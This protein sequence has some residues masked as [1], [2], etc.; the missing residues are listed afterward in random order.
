MCMITTQGETSI[1][2]RDITCWK[3]VEILS[4][5][6][7]ERIYATPYMFRH[8][9]QDVLDGKRPFWTGQPERTYELCEGMCNHILKGFIHTY[10]VPVTGDEIDAAVS[11]LT[12][13]IASVNSHE[14]YLT[15][16][17]MRGLPNCDMLPWVIGVALYRCV[18][19]KGTEYLEGVSDG[20]VDSR[21]YASREI[22]FKEKVVEWNSRYCPDMKERIISVINDMTE[23]GIPM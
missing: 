9:P 21:C 3:V 19:P 6:D 11:E 22:V 2:D 17:K 7:G 5:M 16:E 10:A 20:S 8:V 4:D 14:T 13:A 12:Y 18:I 15:A 23:R 1:A